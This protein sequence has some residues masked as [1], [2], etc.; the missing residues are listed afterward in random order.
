[1]TYLRSIC[2]VNFDKMHEAIGMTPVL[3]LLCSFPNRTLVSCHWRILLELV[4]EPYI[5]YVLSLGKAS[6][7]EVNDLF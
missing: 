5:V 3:Q 1:M 6:R 4:N 7:E 2:P